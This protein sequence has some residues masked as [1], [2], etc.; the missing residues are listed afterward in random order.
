MG[1]MQESM[2]QIH[3]NHGGYAGNHETHAYNHGEYAENHQTNMAT[4]E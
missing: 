2:R 3:N 4:R 1:N